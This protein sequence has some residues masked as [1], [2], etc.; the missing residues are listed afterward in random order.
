[1]LK[2]LGAFLTENMKILFTADVH[3]KLG[4]KNVPV[5]WSKNRYEMLMDQLWELQD[6]ADV[7]VIGGDIFD[8]LPN[9]EEL[10]VYFDFVASCKIKTYIYSGNHEALKKDTT[11]LT[12]LKDVTTKLN[13]LVAIIDECFS[14]E[15]V[16]FLPY[17]RLKSY[18]PADYDF[19]GDILCTH[20]RG[21][22]P[23]HVK[24]EVNLEIFDRWRVVLAGDLHSYD[25]CQR[26]ILYPG[27]PVTTSFHRH[28]V[29]TGVIILDTVSFE[30]TWE[31]LSLPQ[32]IRKTVKAGEPMPPTDYDHTIYEVEGD[33]SELSVLE[34]S[35]LIDKKVVKRDT[36]TA[37]ILGPEMTL[38]QEVSEYLQYVLELTDEGI[39]KALR[40]FN[41]YANKV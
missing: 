28:H 16:D 39:E 41:S 29:D 40:E 33:L 22:I 37:L 24:P 3:I 35:D 12:Y 5:D 14:I 8:K 30:H 20:V 27:S 15:N 23:P 38:E 4:Q 1:M 31:K 11:F 2:D 34:D 18:H 6:K 10:E 32:L 25:N 36:D 26:N 9:M 7:F 19:H 21:E 17:N 13:P